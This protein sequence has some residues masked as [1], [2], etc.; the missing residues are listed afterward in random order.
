[1]VFGVYLF[2]VQ[3]LFVFFFQAE[4][5]IR[6]GH[7]TG[8][9][10]CA[11]PILNPQLH[12]WIYGFRQHS[13]AQQMRDGGYRPLVFMQHGLM[14]AMWM[15]MTTLV[16]AWLWKSKTVRQIGE[17]PMYLLVPA[18]LFTVYLCKSKYAVLLLV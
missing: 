16:G 7:V 9:Q 14:V 8:V 4:D 5:G 3:Y 18:M 11:L 10:T 6:D 2:I 17:V 1:M 13:F 15:A 12:L